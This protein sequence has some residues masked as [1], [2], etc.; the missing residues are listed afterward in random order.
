MLPPRQTA[1]STA[2]PCCITAGSLESNWTVSTRSTKSSRCQASTWISDRYGEAA[3]RWNYLNR[4]LKNWPDWH[5]KRSS[6]G[7]F[8]L[9]ARHSQ[10]ARRCDR[11]DEPTNRIGV[12][13]GRPPGREGHQVPT[14]GPT[15]RLHCDERRVQCVPSWYC[16]AQSHGAHGA[17]RVRPELDCFQRAL[18]LVDLGHSR[19]RSRGRRGRRHQRDLDRCYQDSSGPQVDPPTSPQRRS[20]TGFD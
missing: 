13:G 9:W 5:P 12:T 14:E 18:G 11:H 8:V 2:T 16:R 7:T 20:S 3:R 6:A 15:L 10:A 19:D 4:P 1:S 17:R